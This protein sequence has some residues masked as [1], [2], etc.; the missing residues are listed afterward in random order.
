MYDR[1]L[2]YIIF[3]RMHLHLVN[4][5]L[6]LRDWSTTILFCLKSYTMLITFILPLNKYRHVTKILENLIFITYS[7]YYNIENNFQL[8]LKVY[9]S[10]LSK[11]SK[12]RE[13]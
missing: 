5:F 7:F 8:Y 11:Q 12:F 4:A 10:K 13:R 6:H 9:I 1:V 3:Y 2:E